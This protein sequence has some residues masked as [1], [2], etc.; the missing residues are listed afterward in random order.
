MG[1]E[2]QDRSGP[3]S[4]EV[5]APNSPRHPIFNPLSMYCVVTNVPLSVANFLVPPRAVSATYGCV[6]LVSFFRGYGLHSSMRTMVI[7]YVRGKFD[8][9]EGEEHFWA[10]HGMSVYDWE[11]WMEEDGVYGNT[12]AQFSRCAQT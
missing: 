7:G 9:P 2:Y 6:I 5:T 8:T 3:V 1:Y 12:H 4:F 11:A 10:H